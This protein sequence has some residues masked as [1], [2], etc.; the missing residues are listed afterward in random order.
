MFEPFQ[1]RGK[2]PHIK[3]THLKTKNNS[4]IQPL[5]IRFNKRYLLEELKLPR[6]NLIQVPASFISIWETDF[7]GMVKIINTLSNQN[8]RNSYYTLFIKSIDLI[9]ITFDVQYNDKR[10]YRIRYSPFEFRTS[11]FLKEQFQLVGYNQCLSVIPDT[12]I[13]TA[14]SDQDFYQTPRCFIF[15]DL[16]DNNM[17]AKIVMRTNIFHNAY[18]ISRGM[19]NP[20]PTGLEAD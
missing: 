9:S 19:H 15:D 5:E 16:T 14:I 6:S 10:S 18:S 2:H 8:D 1:Q 17:F 13:K 20:N 11:V 7:C 3:F 4:A 12:S